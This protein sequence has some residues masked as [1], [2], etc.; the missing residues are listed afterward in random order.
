M[1][2]VKQF[3]V[4]I[5][6]SAW[7]LMSEQEKQALFSKLT[8]KVF[9]PEDGLDRVKIKP[10]PEVKKLKRKIREARV[11]PVIGMLYGEDGQKQMYVTR[12]LAEELRREGLDSMVIYFG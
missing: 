10:L 4:N 11:E 3:S 8:P 9:E 1:P 6:L 5:P 2:V 7:T 12:T